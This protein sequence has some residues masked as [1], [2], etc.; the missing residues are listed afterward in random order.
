V[1]ALCAQNRKEKHK[2]AQLALFV[3]TRPTRIS[4]SKPIEEVKMNPKNCKWSMVYNLDSR[5]AVCTKANPK[6]CKRPMLK[7]DVRAT[8]EG[9]VI[10]IGIVVGLVQLVKDA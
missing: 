10:I 8:P 2:L 6:I 5:R 9:V 1:T 3:G 7:N 4:F